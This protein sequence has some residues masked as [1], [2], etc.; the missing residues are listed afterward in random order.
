MNSTLAILGNHPSTRGDFDFSRTHCDVVVF[1]EM[2]QFSWVECA[3]YVIQLHLP[4]IWRSKTNRNNKDHYDWLK[5]GE[6]PTILMIDKYEDVPNSVKFPLEEIIEAMPNT[7]KY[8]TS[9]VAYAIAW[10][11]YSGYKTIEFYG[12]EMATNT[13]YSHQRIGVAYWCGVAAGKGINIE[14]HSNTFFVAPLYGY[15][16]DIRIPLEYFDERK[17]KITDNLEPT[18]T[19]YKQQFNAIK[20]LTDDWVESYK[21][22][23]DQLDRVILGLGQLSH[24]YAMLNGSAQVLDSY[25][26]RCEEMIKESGSY[27][28]SRQE[29]EMEI[30]ASMQAIQ[31]RYS[32][33]KEVADK[34]HSIREEMKTNANMEIRKRIVE[35]LRKQITEYAKATADIGLPSGVMHENRTLVFKHDSLLKDAGVTPD[36]AVEINEETL[37]QYEEQEDMYEVESVNA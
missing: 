30:A 3:D 16:G 13:E 8:F 29:F 11:I 14:F 1:N 4:L 9:S 10:G 28:I 23:L 17:K 33:M 6:T 20:K 18:Q 26:G 24:N 19:A 12:V 21:T 35:R 22:D 2:M 15:E 36:E 27:I 32:R 37:K 25:K 31:K 7:V 5:S 34:I